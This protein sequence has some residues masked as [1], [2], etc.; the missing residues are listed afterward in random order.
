MCSCPSIFALTHK[1]VFDWLI[2]N[3]L[4]LME[5]DLGL[6]VDLASKMKCRIPL[7]SHA[8]QIYGMLSD[9]G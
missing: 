2:E 6:A 5:K 9:H 7:G 8:H 4:G 3:L 1:Y